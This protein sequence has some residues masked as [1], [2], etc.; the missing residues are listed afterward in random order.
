MGN[1]VKGGLTFA[2]YLFYLYAASII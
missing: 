2:I 1:R